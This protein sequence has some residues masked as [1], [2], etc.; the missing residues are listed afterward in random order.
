MSDNVGKM[1]ENQLR[2]QKNG[3][4]GEWNILQAYGKSRFRMFTLLYPES[5]LQLQCCSSISGIILHLK[6]V[7]DAD[8]IGVVY[9]A[10]REIVWYSQ[11]A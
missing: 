8:T 3:F 2:T 7:S 11:P 4:A 6:P 9:E 1:T 10:S 5:V